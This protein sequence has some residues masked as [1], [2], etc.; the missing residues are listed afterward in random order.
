MRGYREVFVKHFG[1]F[2][3]NIRK[4]KKEKKKK[5]KPQLRFAFQTL[6]S[7]SNQ[8]ALVH[9]RALG[10]RNQGDLVSVVCVFWTF[11]SRK[12]P[13]PFDNGQGFPKETHSK[14]LPVPLESS[15]E[16]GILVHTVVSCNLRSLM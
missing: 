7:A 3:L 2:F 11:A 15:M 14:Y 8:V 1:T 9:I 13:V 12:I 10:Y 16:N 4:Q 6:R 5:K